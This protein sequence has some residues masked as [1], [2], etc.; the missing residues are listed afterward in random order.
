MA[1]WS[2]MLMALLILFTS[3]CIRR[4]TTKGKR[5]KLPSLEYYRHVGAKEALE[6]FNSKAKELAKE[7]AAETIALLFHKAD[8]GDLDACIE[9]VSK[10]VICK[11]GMFFVIP[12]ESPTYETP[13]IFMDNPPQFPEG[14][15]EKDGA[16]TAVNEYNM[17]TK[18]EHM[19]YSKQRTP[20]V[21]ADNRLQW[22]EPLGYQDSRLGFWLA[23]CEFEYSN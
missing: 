7:N 2:L 8:K 14:L 5:L 17:Q 12:P 19:D 18:P 9:E 23:N 21:H 11:Y 16:E 3:I 15:L 6:Q 20:A 1:G 10:K 13:V 4:C 22:P